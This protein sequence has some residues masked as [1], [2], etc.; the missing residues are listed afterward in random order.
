MTVNLL[1]S[2]GQLIYSLCL[3]FGYY[4]YAFYYD[5]E[6]KEDIWPSSFTLRPGFTSRM[7]S[8]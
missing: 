2:Y 3:L 1:Q 8:F 5:K 4:F 7:H 6:A